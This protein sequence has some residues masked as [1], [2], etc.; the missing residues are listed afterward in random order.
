MKRR[1]FLQG[2]GAAAAASPARASA[3]R[4]ALEEAS[5]T[6]LA[7]A[8]AEGRTT[9]VDLVAGYLDRIEAIDRAGPA[10][11]SVIE[12]NPE[13]AAI[14]EQ[15]DR[16]RHAGRLRGPLHGLPV[17]VKDNIASGDRMETSAGSP[18]LVGAR[19]PR[20]AHVVKR[21]RDAGALLLGK[22]NL[23][24]WAN[25]RGKHSISGWSTRGGQT[26]NPYALDRSPSGSS[27]GSASA[28]AASLAALAVGTETDGSIT[29]PASCN[30]L[31][32]VKPTVGLVSR[33]GIVPISFSQDTA[34]PMCRTVADAALLLAA[35]AG[36]DPR[37]AAT[38]A[39]AGRAEL[40]SLGTLRPDGLRGARLG[41]AE[42]LVGDHLGTA[43]RFEDTLALLRDAGA[44]LVKA[45]LPPIEK[46]WEPEFEVLL[47][48]MQH[49]MPA[50]LAEFAPKSPH[51]S[52][53]DLVAYHRANP[54]TL[55]LFGQEYFEQAATKRGLRNP[56]Y[57]KALAVARRMARAE[58]IDAALR[59]HR[60]DALIAPTCGPAWLIDTVHGDMNVASATSF[61]AV[62]GYP[63]VTVPMG[64]VA[65]LPVGLSFFAG[66][67][68]EVRLLNLAHG[69]EQIAQARRAPTYRQSVTA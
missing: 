51:R 64:Q 57:R 4:I 11:R 68:S 54:S 44:V 8:L 36:V 55:S 5:A 29:S 63:H 42:N 47:V 15:L 2:A 49:A 32:G 66:A 17:L 30:G 33:D 3:G 40:A 43:R 19:A 7:S 12:L 21:L 65:G 59:K 35:M 50:Y 31:V 16:E 38:R 45:P 56:A 28:M 34:G 23:S 22:T 60:L 26:R 58:G 9:S 25:I 6:E 37:D 48:E 67:W 14:A 62:A 41:V 52:L 1:V 18:A 24:E 13:A 61:A 20:D 53:A 46:L 69:F 39:Q 27:S 10:L